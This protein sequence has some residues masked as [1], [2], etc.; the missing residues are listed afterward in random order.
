MA[1]DLRDKATEN[2]LNNIVIMV[3][4]AYVLKAAERKQLNIEC[5]QIFINHRWFPAL[6]INAFLSNVLL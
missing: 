1:G 5:Y 4:K 2:Y 6:G 3:A